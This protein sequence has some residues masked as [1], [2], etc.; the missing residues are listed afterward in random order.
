MPLTALAI[1][2]GAGVLKSEI[3]DRPKEARQRKLAAETARYSPWTG[4]QPQGVQEADPL[5]SALAFGG[6]GSQLGAAMQQQALNQKIAEQM[7]QQQQPVKQAG[8]VVQ[9]T[10]ARAP[11]WSQ[12]G[13]YGY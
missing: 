11:I 1:G 5:G 8:P 4:M 7:M 6:A 12:V 3:V 9:P 13:N 2:A 10:I